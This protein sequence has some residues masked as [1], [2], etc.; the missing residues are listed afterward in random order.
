LL[1]LAKAKIQKS[2]MICLNLWII[3]SSIPNN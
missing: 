3:T 1:L 2:P